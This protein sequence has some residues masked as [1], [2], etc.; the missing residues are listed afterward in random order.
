MKEFKDDKG[1]KP[2]ANLEIEENNE[3]KV[4]GMSR[5]ASD[6]SVWSKLVRLGV[7]MQNEGKSLVG[8]TI[9]VRVNGKDK[10]KSY[11]IDELYPYIE[12]QSVQNNKPALTP[13]KEV[14]QPSGKKAVIDMSD[15]PIESMV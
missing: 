13:I 11:D 6:K 4:W 8:S 12:K 14:V 2:R 10:E 5:S 15:H 9:T 3:K 1:P 7:F